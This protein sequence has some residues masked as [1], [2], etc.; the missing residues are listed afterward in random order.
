VKD[1]KVFF[2]IFE[3]FIDN[4]CDEEYNF[5][6][7]ELGMHAASEDSYLDNKFSV[8]GTIEDLLKD[9]SVEEILEMTGIQLDNEE[10]TFDYDVGIEEYNDIIKHNVNKYKTKKALKD[11][12]GFNFVSDNIIDLLVP[13]EN[14]FDLI[15]FSGEIRN[16][17]DY[18]NLFIDKIFELHT[19]NRTPI[20]NL[21]INVIGRLIE[22]ERVN[23]E[24][25]LN[26]GLSY[27]EY[28][29]F[30]S[31][32]K[33]KLECIDKIKIN[34][35]HEYIEDK[36]NDEILALINLPDKSNG[37]PLYSLIIK[38]K[39]TKLYKDLLFKT[40]TLFNKDSLK[41][42]QF[43]KEIKRMIKF[44]VFKEEKKDRTSRFKN[45]I[46]E[47]L[48]SV[49]KLEIQYRFIS[50]VV[51][52]CREYKSLIKEKQPKLNI[53]E[54][55]SVED[56]FDSIN[57]L[58]E[59]SD[60]KKFI[61]SIIGSYKHLATESNLN[62]LSE[63]RSNKVEKNLIK[64]EVKGLALVK[65][66]NVLGKQLKRI[67]YS[68]FG[69]IISENVLKKTIKI[70]K[71][72]AN[73]IF[74][75]NDL[76]GVVLGDVNT[77]EALTPSKWCIS[78]NDYLFNNYKGEGENIIIFDFK[79]EMEDRNS[80]IG[81]S[82]YKNGRIKSAFDKNNRVVSNIEESLGLDTSIKIKSELIKHAYSKE[83]KKV[84]LGILDIDDAIDP[85]YIINNSTKLSS[86]SKFDEK[87]KT[88]IMTSI[89]CSELNTNEILKNIISL[90]KKKPELL[91]LS[92]K[93]VQETLKKENHPLTF[94][95]EKENNKKSIKSSFILK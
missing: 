75:D 54:M 22:L 64:E 21:K 12:P 92:N 27:N 68:D 89:K 8:S 19:I 69:S 40:K 81:L 6:V 36:I 65:D 17:I 73:I 15:D 42:N 72:D 1:K 31:N 55:E 63:L 23:I 56:L 45:S 82:T 53:K 38:D 47:R 77:S 24:K 93:L 85:I 35:N 90:S 49:D 60:N 16:E 95:N 76:V 18:A 46:D 43:Y 84:E 3:D 94:I 4:I 10:I 14:N 7:S 58:I 87:M 78:K 29:K 50:D 25:K 2:D 33:K 39:E 28:S 32:L 70:K 62:L 91:I 37:E 67:L 86:N 61:K 52:L 71:L 30:N 5:G 13:F 80:I 83:L 57:V 41:L 20:S 26:K 44:E 74:S 88:Y 51:S 48:Y 34:I 79:K 59:E 9:Y 66:P 11:S